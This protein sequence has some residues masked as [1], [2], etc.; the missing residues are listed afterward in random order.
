[1]HPFIEAYFKDQ[2]ILEVKRLS[3]AGSSRIY[4]RVF[5]KQGVYIACENHHLPENE[6]FIAFA[7]Y[8]KSKG[9]LVPEVYAT[10]PDKQCY[11][12]QDLG[13]LNLLDYRMRNGLIEEVRSYYEKSLQQL[14]KM[15]LEAAKDFNYQLC[16]AAQKF[17]QEAVLA[18]LQY[19]KYYFIDLHEIPYDKIAL[20]KEFQ[21]LA[22]S[23][24]D[25]ALSGFMFRDF[26]SRN[27]M[28]QDTQAYFID[29]QGGMR[30]PVAYDVVSL[31][32]QAKADLND[33]WKSGL[34][35]TYEA[36]LMEQN[37]SIE[38][39]RADYPKVLL[40]RLLQ[41]MGAYGFRGLV[42]RKL[43]FQTSIPKGLSN[44]ETYLSTYDMHEYPEL[45]GLL[46]WIT[47]PEFKQRFEIPVSDEQTRLKVR[48]GSFSYKKGIPED[49]SGNGGGFVFDC[50]GLLNPGRFE[51]YKK[52]TGRDQDVIKFL[53]EKTRI[54]AFLDGVFQAVDIS[55][56]DYLKRG[57]ENLMIHFGCTGGQHRSVYCADALAKH[58]NQKYGLQADVYHR[59]Q[60]ARQWK[61]D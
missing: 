26:Q 10:S 14:A 44:L 13:D 46:T 18:D 27:I 34:L 60:E 59:E 6:S 16:F 58:L 37:Q 28:I 24:S 17:D 21:V 45:R 36:A 5:C 48:I 7:K 56:E 61:Y 25:C 43:H 38:A 47:T 33:E 11:I 29:F 3:A 9:I 39:F 51:A 42:Q 2:N 57:F 23:I 40:I 53:E 22:E 4:H 12:L 30:G 52:R 31:L 54:K 15:Q 35:Q 1:M 41:V 50:R 55:V 19:F 8:F 32:W 49:E 20:Q